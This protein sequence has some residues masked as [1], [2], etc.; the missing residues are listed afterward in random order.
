MRQGAYGRLENKYLYNGKEKQGSEF[1]DNSGLEWYDFG[2]RMQDMQLGRWFGIDPLAD[3]MRR[4]SPYAYAF[5]NPV[6][7][8]DPDGMM[9]VRSNR[10]VSGYLADQLTRWCPSEG[11]VKDDNSGKLLRQNSNNWNAKRSNT[12]DA[13]L[14]ENASVESDDWSDLDK[15]ILKEYVRL[16]NPN[17]SNGQLENFMGDLFE[18]LWHRSAIESGFLR[19]NYSINNSKMTGGTRNTVPDATADGIIRTPWWEDDIRVSKAAWFEVK[20]KNG[21]I[22][23]STSTGQT[24][25]HIQNMAIQIPGQFRN[26]GKM[27][28]SA[29]SLTFVTTSNVSIS[30]SVVVMATVYNI[31]IYQYKAQYNINNGII[32][33]R[34]KLTSKNGLSFSGQTTKPVQVN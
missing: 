26:Y 34:F 4:W 3:Q 1:S 17:F 20:A 30:P 29:A 6:R 5:D 10:S 19:D 2:A 13:S 33:V 12:S 21:N 14:T 28:A 7:F 24:L 27:H 25:G 18:N 23:N 11:G 31:V 22:Y 15:T 32:S 9:A 16:L 8:V